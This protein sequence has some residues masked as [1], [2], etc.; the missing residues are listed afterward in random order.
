L[1]SR[2]TFYIEGASIVWE[3]EA[4]CLIYLKGEGDKNLDL[5]S[6][7]SQK[8]LKLLLPDVTFKAKKTRNSI[9]DGR[10]SI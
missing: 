9:P 7:L 1:Q 4:R 8:Y 10:P 5:V 6:S 2:I 3:T